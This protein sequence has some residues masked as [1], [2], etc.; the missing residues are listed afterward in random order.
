MKEVL[1]NASKPGCD[2]AFEHESDE[3][4]I[5]EAASCSPSTVP[6]PKRAKITQHAQIESAPARETGELPSTGG[7]GSSLLQAVKSGMG[8]SDRGASRPQPLQFLAT[9]NLKVVQTACGKRHSVRPRVRRTAVGYEQLAAA[10]SI[11]APGKAQ[12]S[13]YGIDIHTLIETA[14]AEAKIHAE[15]TG[16]T[17][18][19]PDQPMQS[20]ERGS[21]QLWSEKY[22]ARKFTDLIGDDRTHR[23]VMHWLKR[24]DHIVFPGSKARPKI[25]QTGDRDMQQTQHRKVMLLTGPPGL[26]KTTLAHVC[27]RQAGYEIQEINAS[28][29]R[30]R[31]VVH[32]RIRDMVGTENVK[33]GAT[34]TVN[35]LAT[36]RRAARPVCVVVDEVDGAVAGAGGSGEGGFIKALL[37]LLNTDHRNANRPTL[38][39]GATVRAKKKG[40]NFRMLRPLILICNDVYHPALRL[41]RQSPHAEIIH[42]G[43]P[44]LHNVAARLVSIFN[45]EGVPADSD[46]VRKLCEASWGV[47]NRKESNGGHGTGEGDVRTIM[48]MAEWVA[49]RF[50]ASCM[51]P[52]AGPQRL[53]KRWVEDVFLEEATRSGGAARGLGR[54]GAKEIVDRVFLEGAGLYKSTAAAASTNTVQVK[55]NGVKGVAEAAKSATMHNLRELVNSGDSDKIM[56]EC[57]ASYPDHPWHDDTMLSKPAAAYDWLFLHDA[58]SSAVFQTNEWEL[59][60]YLCQ[61]IL[62]FHHLFATSRTAR[63]RHTARQDP[64]SPDDIHPLRTAQASYAAHEALKSHT[65]ILD[66]LRPGLSLPLSQ[67]FPTTSTLA[68]DLA[69]FLSRLLSPPVN[70]VLITTGGSGDNK[71]TSTASIR[72]ASEKLLVDRA[73][74]ALLATGI[75]FDRLRL[76]TTASTV[77]NT[78]IAAGLSKQHAGWIYRMEPALDVF[79]VYGTADAK[80]EIAVGNDVNAAGQRF[81][82]RQILDQE[83]ARHLA[84]EEA[85]ARQRR[86]DAGNPTRSGAAEG[87]Q[88]GEKARGAGLGRRAVQGTLRDTDPAFHQ[89][90]NPVTTKRDFFGREVVVA[91][92]AAGTGLAGEG[93]SGDEHSA[94]RKKVWVSYNEGFSSA[95]RKPLSLAELMR[96]FG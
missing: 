91:T 68:T 85:E 26:G 17:S 64:D 79:G 4:N 43:K 70:P 78:N 54:G 15:T 33:Q 51:D 24:W 90:R 32:G 20:T 13:Y 18:L 95:V 9:S 5:P 93:K 21:G 55:I 1:N 35:G 27:A 61:P 48:V 46:A 65:A 25:A 63:S 71:H 37:D 50:R 62:A 67:Q 84:R 89:T 52:T 86:F 2:A 11:V 44:V 92:D 30:S 82:V 16:T 6:S 47:T 60:P 49:G 12:R 3:E 34:K 23:Q 66:T 38:H 56:A 94:A 72:K 69:P 14:E 8:S 83:R 88:E 29:E 42:A 77:P 45:R 81:A 74:N 10:R 87:T 96:E 73:V 59:A 39:G 36:A 57:F 75:S 28:D 31:N 22:R 76:D 41:L 80:S 53:T 40:D 7:L 19:N 58:L